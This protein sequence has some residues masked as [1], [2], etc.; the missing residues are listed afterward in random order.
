MKHLLYFTLFSSSLLAFDAYKY[1]SDPSICFHNPQIN[2]EII[3]ATYL[4]YGEVKTLEAHSSWYEANTEP[5]YYY[6]SQCNNNPYD[7]GLDS[8]I[9]NDWE[10]L[11][12]EESQ[13][14]FLMGLTA[15]LL[16]FTLVFLVGFLFVLQ[17]R[18]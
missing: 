9:S 12:L 17:G 2:G 1:N 10:E 14:H 5:S 16:G 7:S 4:Q 3:T 18:R 11:G 13:Y 6:N 15:N 8:N